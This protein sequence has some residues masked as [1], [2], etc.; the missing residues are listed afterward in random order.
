MPFG[1][2]WT[3]LTVYIIRRN[4]TGDNH[5]TSAVQHE[6]SP[7]NRHRSVVMLRFPRPDDCGYSKHIEN[8]VYWQSVAHRHN[9]GT[10]CPCSE[11][12]S[13]HKQALACRG[14]GDNCPH[15]RLRSRVVTY[16]GMSKLSW[17]RSRTAH[18]WLSFAT[19]RYCPSLHRSVMS[20]CSCSGRMS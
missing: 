16:S 5:K 12:F 7:T 14:K 17:L 11:E 10:E 18:V 13:I 1:S 2:C 8:S 9:P 15:I 20:S 4:H 6:P 3:A 19:L